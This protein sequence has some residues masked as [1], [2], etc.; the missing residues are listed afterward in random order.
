[1]DILRC[2]GLEVGTFAPLYLAAIVG[3]VVTNFMMTIPADVRRF[4]NGSVSIWPRPKARTNFKES[5][6]LP[7]F[8]GG[9]LCLPS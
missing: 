4:N 9:S 1:M 7:Q 5:F 8:V 3:G 6:N 2:C